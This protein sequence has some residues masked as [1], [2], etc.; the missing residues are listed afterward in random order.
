MDCC[1]APGGKTTY[2]AEQMKDRGMINAWDLYSNRLQLVEQNAKRLGIH[3]IHTQEKDASKLD[4][5][6]KEQYDRVLL[7]VP[8]LGLG[9][10]RRKPDIKWKRKPEDIKEIQKIQMD[11]LHTCSQYVKIGGYLVYSTC[12]ILP[13]ENENIIMEFLKEETFELLDPKENLNE[14]KK[15][16]ITEE[17]W[18]HFYPNE[19]QDGFFICYLKRKK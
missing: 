8:C 9:V 2:L 11:I 15:E 18:I 17:K 12:S 10:I 3:I 16:S 4:E 1:S 14:E 7:D 5:E 6:E 13:E 19:S